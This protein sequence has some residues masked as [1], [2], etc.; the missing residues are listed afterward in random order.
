MITRS[1]AKEGSDLK[2]LLD[3]FWSFEMKFH[4]STDWCKFCNNHMA[5][6]GGELTQSVWTL[7]GA[8]VTPGSPE[9]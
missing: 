4:S 1:C 6:A 8:K 2:F 7:S 9:G 3:I 5:K